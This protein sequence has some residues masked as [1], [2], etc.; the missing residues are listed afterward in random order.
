M[1]SSSFS[2]PGLLVAGF[3]ILF[4]SV[5]TSLSA[6]EVSFLLETPNAVV[7]PGESF[8][9]SIHL[10]NLDSISIQGIQHVVSWDSSRLQLL[11]LTL[12]G[13]LEG[14][15]TPLALAWNA[16]P[17]AGPGGDVGCSQWW[18]GEALEAFSFAMVVDGDWDQSQTPLAQLE[19][20]VLS[21]SSNGSSTL[22][23]P[24]PDFSC[25]WLGS[26]VTDSRG[27]IVPTN[28]Q[29]LPIQIS[30]LPPPTPFDCAEASGTVYLSW[31]ESQAY[32]SIR[33][34]RDGV[35]IGEIAGGIGTFEDSDAELGSTPDYQIS[36]IVAS[37][38]SPASSCSV[39]VDGIIDAPDALSCLDNGTGVLL[40]WQ[41]RLPYAGL[42]I[43]RQG[44]FYQTVA[45]GTSTFVDTAP[46]AGIPVIY[47]VL[48]VIAG[49]QGQGSQCEI[50]LP[51]PDLFFIRGDVTTDGQLNLSDPVVTLQYLFVGGEM[52]CASAADHDD[53]GTL[54]LGDGVS[55]LSYL[56]A[57]G[58]PP[59]LPFP[60]AGTD[61]TPDS[62]GCLEPCPDIE[63]GGVQEGDECLTSIPVGLGFTNFDNTNMTD[64][65]DPYDD[66]LCPNNFL[67][68][69]TQ[70]VWFSFTA[71]ASGLATVSTCFSS[72]VPDTD[73][74]IYEG[75]CGSLLQIACSGD[76]PGCSLLAQVQGLAVTEG[77]TYLIRI[78][79]WAP[80]EF[81]PGILSITID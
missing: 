43:N 20:R 15:P 61:P 13:D 44:D 31:I 8:T 71:P 47:E 37:V 4:P 53:S 26:I 66:L 74:V 67:G 28:S 21:A 41:N 63:C 75:S 30:N 40:T 57:G 32:D 59:A 7:A 72:T 34:E 24:A 36:G 78:G 62:L 68:Q 22:E 29:S 54:D 1:N 12:P 35:T 69:M 11:S 70:D 6:Q 5:S 18:D 81:G 23:S 45:A 60:T 73:L 33:I 38:P 48:G 80:L 2:L 58:S 50:E 79:G 3:M 42:V 56:F 49:E 55:L 27:N 39:T 14:S 25:G 64:S 9:V 77:T 52:P 65:P 51:Q 16:P 10:E 46:I 76:F 17:P 19:M